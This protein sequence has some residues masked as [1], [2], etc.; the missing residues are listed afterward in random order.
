VQI[1]RSITEISRLGGVCID[2]L[3]DLLQNLFSLR[4][5]AP[6]RQ[7]LMHTHLLFDVARRQDE[8]KP[9]LGNAAKRLWRM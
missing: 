8:R 3:Q 9:C 5:M 4:G 6:R 2:D 7:G 1:R